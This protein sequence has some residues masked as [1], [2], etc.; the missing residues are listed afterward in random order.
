MPVDDTTQQFTLLARSHSS[1]LPDD[2]KLARTSAIFKGLAVL[3]LISL[4]IVFTVK[5]SKVRKGDTPGYDVVGKLTF[6]SLCFAFLTKPLLAVLEWII[7][8]C[9]NGYLLTFVYDF[10][11]ARSPKP[12]SEYTN[13]HVTHV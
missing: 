4:G 10:R 5:L 11:H 8:F 12:I 9:F 1:R 13:G 7:A 2:Y 3:V 6:C